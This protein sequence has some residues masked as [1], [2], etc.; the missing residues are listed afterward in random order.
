MYFNSSNTFLKN[1]DR[2]NS[3]RRYLK[4]APDS[5]TNAWH[6][7]TTVTGDTRDYFKEVIDD[8]LFDANDVENSLHAIAQNHSKD[9][10]MWR[11]LIIACPDVLCNT[12]VTA[13]GSNRFIRWNTERTQYGHKKDCA[14]NYEIDLLPGTAI[15]GYHAEL[16]SL[17]KYYELKDKTF[18]NRGNVK[19]QRTKT[20]INQPYLYL[21]S[22]EAPDVMVFYQ[23]DGCFRFVFKDG[24]E[25]LDIAYADVESKLASL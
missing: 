16:F 18:G 21:G 7:H 23:D 5:E 9:I 13:L 19:Y 25:L 20:N 1:A 6:P 3:W 10:P 8:P 4:A 17:C 2:D 14:D 12:S 22:E 11:K 15:T 24:T